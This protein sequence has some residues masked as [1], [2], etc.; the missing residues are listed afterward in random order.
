MARKLS[1]QR[2]VYV[3]AAIVIVVT[4]LWAVL[5][6]PRLDVHPQAIRDRVDRSSKIFFA[7]QSD[8]RG[9]LN[10]MCGS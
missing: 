8:I 9:R 4:A 1:S 6:L 2:M 5:F 3:A 10:G 7:I